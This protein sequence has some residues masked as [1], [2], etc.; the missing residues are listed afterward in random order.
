[1]GLAGVSCRDRILAARPSA[2]S[3]AT[4]ARRMVSLTLVIV[5]PPVATSRKL[6][7]KGFKFMVSFSLR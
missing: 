6:A 4:S 5:Q 1:M 3:L 2:D 7:I